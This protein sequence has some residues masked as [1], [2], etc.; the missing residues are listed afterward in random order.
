MSW[1][2]KLNKISQEYYRREKDSHEQVNCRAVCPLEDNVVR[3]ANYKPVSIERVRG[4]LQ[5]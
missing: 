1:A 5:S 4:G 2:G 3:I